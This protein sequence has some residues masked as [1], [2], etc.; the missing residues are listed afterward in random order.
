[1]GVTERATRPL[2]VT[3]AVFNW[4]VALSLALPGDA[5]WRLV[6]LARPADTLFLHLSLTFIALFGVAYFWIGV[7]PAG[8]APLVVIGAVGKVAAFAVVFGHYL[9]GSIPAGV[10]LLGAG[11]LVFAA[12]FLGFLAQDERTS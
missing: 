8:K 11:D 1:M 2:F 10:A 9:A 6:G 12:L 4:L 7:A 3:A 5:A